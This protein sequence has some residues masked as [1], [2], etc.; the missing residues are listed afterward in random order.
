M[1][2][3]VG[4]SVML[5]MTIVVI[6]ISTQKDVFAALKY[7]RF[8]QGKIKIQFQDKA[9]SSDVIYKTVG[10]IIHKTPISTMDAFHKERF[11]QMV[12]DGVVE[13][14]KETL[15]DGSVITDFEIAE[16]RVLLALTQGDLLNVEE[17]GTVYLD[18]VFEVRNKATGQ[19]IGNKYYYT[20][21]AIVNAAPWGEK[22]KEDLKAYYNIPIQFEG[23]TYPAYKE[24][25]INGK[26]YSREE[27]GMFKAGEDISVEFPL[28]IEV[29]GKKCVLKKTYLEEN[30][31]RGKP[32]DVVTY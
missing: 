12:G 8:E 16:D 10:W 30:Q 3:R 20:Y 11:G 22:T 7:I 28:E 15:P 13:V 27:L 6:L 25:M 31:K 24:I 2:K 19:R 4:V 32:I 5:V 23:S 29:D 21:N 26:L 1:K 9:A 14:G 18:S 17:G